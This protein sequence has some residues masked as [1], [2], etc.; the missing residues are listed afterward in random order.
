MQ[1]QDPVEEYLRRYGPKKP[2][3]VAQG[4]GVPTA[5]S[6]P[7]AEYVQQYRAQKEAEGPEAPPPD[8]RRAEA[9]GFSVS[10]GL[11]ANFDDHIA[12]AAA[13]TAEG[14]TGG[15]PVKTYKAAL[16]DWRTKSAESRAQHPSL[17]L[18]GEVGGALVAPG[19]AMALGKTVLG[20]MGA[21]ALVGGAQGGAAALG[22]SEGTTPGEKVEDTMWGTLFGAGAGGLLPAVPALGRFAAD[23]LPVRPKNSMMPSVGASANMGIP[24]TRENLETAH[25]TL[26]RSTQERADDKILR[27][28]ERDRI[29]PEMLREKGAQAAQSGKPMAMMD[30]AGHNV[31][32]LGRAARSVPGQGANDIEQFLM[33]RGAG[34]EERVLDDLLET[35]KTPRTNIRKEIARLAE[36]RAAE[37]EQLYGK[38]YDLEIDIPELGQFF[39]MAG[40]RKAYERAQQLAISDGVV[41][42]S[43]G[44]LPPLD[45]LLGKDGTLQAPLSV[46]DIDRIKRG[47]D[48][49]MDVGERSPLDAGGLG[50]E[51]LATLREAKNAFLALVDDAV[52]DRAYEA[53]R[54]A[55]G[56]KSAVIKAHAKG[57]KLFQMSPDEAEE[58]LSTMS[59]AEREGF[60]KGAHSAMARRVESIASGHDI[61]KRVGADKTTD[62]KRMRLM[63]EDEAS[64]ERFRGLLT[65]EMTMHGTKNFL[66]GNSQTVD[67]MAALADLAGV[68]VDAMFTGATGGPSAIASLLGRTALGRAVQGNTERVSEEVAKR[69][70]TQA[71][72]PAFTD[73]LNA[74]KQ[75]EIRRAAQAA[76]SSRASAGAGRAAEAGLLRERER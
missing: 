15:N 20:R 34:A 41:K 42:G 30:I 4:P 1:V 55:F 44:R 59:A 25:K 56:G 21:G 74:M 3:V 43:G 71:G 11:L 65:E 51:E 72:T 38:V 2:G 66:R 37:A 32:N 61:G 69:L 63:F 39:E 28:L 50:N 76:R 68:S 48:D 8:P 14:L 64:F 13:A 46:R 40:F 53:A 24:F 58:L 70:T 31:R 5:T 57:E 6:D 33:S 23:A 62:L 47:L 29:A 16:E 7:V 52:P 18:A 9:A 49:V 12:A 10:R 35:T 73:L 45:K 75:A 36:E 19:G 27:D 22:A 60:Q 17:S 67:K 54:Q 26:L